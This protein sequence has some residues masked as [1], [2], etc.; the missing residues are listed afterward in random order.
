LQHHAPFP[1]RSRANAFRHLQLQSR[2]T[3][4]QQQIDAIS[5]LKSPAH[6]SGTGPGT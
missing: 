2:K 3:R 4:M 6:K 5:D 1:A